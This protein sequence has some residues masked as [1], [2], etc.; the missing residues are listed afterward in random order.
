[1]G[2]GSYIFGFFD[3]IIR[4]MREM[5]LRTILTRVKGSGQILSCVVKHVEPLSTLLFFNKIKEYIL[6]S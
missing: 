4:S 2:I 6:A 3:E 1:V 5:P